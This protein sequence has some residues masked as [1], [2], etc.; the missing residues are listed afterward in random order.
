MIPR[1]GAAVITVTTEKLA[2]SQTDHHHKPSISKLVLV[3][4]ICQILMVRLK[5]AL[6]A[7][8]N[9][10]QTSQFATPYLVYLNVSKQINQIT[11]I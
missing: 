11:I 6:E 2:V 7:G 10:N 5:H 8:P 1:D 4:S 9:I 3:S